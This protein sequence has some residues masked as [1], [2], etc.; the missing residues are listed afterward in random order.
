MLIFYIKLHQIEG[1]YSLFLKNDF[2]LCFAKWLFLNINKVYYF[3]IIYLFL[4]NKNKKRV[5]YFYLECSWLKRHTYPPRFYLS[6]SNIQV[7]Y[8][9]IAAII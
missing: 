5:Y 1:K 6:A 3:I 4:Q 7:R 8:I 2:Q 9:T